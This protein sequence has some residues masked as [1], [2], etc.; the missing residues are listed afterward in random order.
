[1]CVSMLPMSFVVE[2]TNTMNI[3]FAVVMLAVH[4]DLKTEVDAISTPILDAHY[5]GACGVIAPFV[6]VRALGEDL[7]LDEIASATEWEIHQG[8]SI[9]Q[10][11]TAITETTDLTVTAKRASPLVL[12]DWLESADHVAIL[13]VHTDPNLPHAVAAVDMSDSHITFIDYPGLTR[14][15]PI[16]EVVLEWNGMAIFVSRGADQYFTTAVSRMPITTAVASVVSVMTIAMACRRR[17][18]AHDKTDRSPQNA[19]YHK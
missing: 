7:G 4:S 17:T 8:V 13:I 14:T 12:R 9:A 3:L 5:A 10:M 16:E 19:L 6:A 18:N 2:Y 15:R 1:M 11:C